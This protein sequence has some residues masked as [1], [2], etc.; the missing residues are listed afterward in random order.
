M[1]LRKICKYYLQIWKLQR[2]RWG[3]RPYC[4]WAE[5]RGSF[6]FLLSRLSYCGTAYEL[7]SSLFHINVP[8][9]TSNISTS[10]CCIITNK[11]KQPSHN[12]LISLIMFCVEWFVARMSQ[13]WQ[14]GQINSFWH[15]Y[16]S[17]RFDR[18]LLIQNF[19]WKQLWKQRNLLG[20]NSFSLFT[21]SLIF[22][23][24]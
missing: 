9:H 22:L 18:F 23:E 21:C 4:M 1:F 5:W 6:L 2:R 8:V 15:V 7:L 19:V 13:T 10:L 17:L 16:S 20:M 11:E 12:Y 14:P 3:I 24:W